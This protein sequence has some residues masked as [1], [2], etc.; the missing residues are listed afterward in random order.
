[1]LNPVHQH[2]LTQESGIAA[3]IIEERAYRTSSGY[4]ELKSLGILV[5][6][7]THTQGLLLPLWT[8]TGKPAQT[9]RAR[10]DRM[11]PLMHYR[12]DTPQVDQE[13]EEAKYLYPGGQP[14]R[15]D[16]HPRSVPL[17]QD[18]QVPLWVT[19]GVKKSDALVSHG[20]C[21]LT[22]LG[23]WNWRGRNAQGGKVALPEWQDIA[24]NGR[25]VRLVF[26]SDIMEKAPVE[27]A[28]LALA[29][30][31]TSKGAHVH[32]AYLPGADGSKVGVDDYLLTHTPADLEHLLEVP[33]RARPKTAASL[34]TLKLNKAQEPRPV[35]FNVL[36][37]L[38]QDPHW[39]GVF[40]YDAF[41]CKETLLARP[42]YL[43]DDGPWPVRQITD[44]DDTETSNWLQREYDLCAST[45][46]IHEAIQAL[47]HRHPYHPVRDYLRR[48][49]WDGTPRLETWLTTYCHAEDTPYH[50]AVG[51]K[52]LVSWVARVEEPGCKADCVTILQGDQGL[53][54]STTWEVLAGKPWFSDT[55]PDIERKDAMENLHGKWIVEL[56][57]LAVMQRSEREAIKRFVSANQDHYRP[58]Y[59]RRAVTFPRQTIFVGT[60][61]KEQI[62]QDETGNRRFWPVRVPKPCD[63]AALQRDRDQLFAE[64]FARYQAGA[65]WYL[66]PGEDTLAV[67]EQ[68]ERFEVDPWEE[69]VLLYVKSLEQVS[70]RQVMEQG[71]EWDNPLLWTQANSKRIGA[72]LRRH[73]WRHQTCRAADGTPFKGFKREIQ[74]TSVTDPPAVTDDTPP[75]GYNVTPYKNNTVTDVTDVTD[76]PIQ[77]ESENVTMTQ[78]SQ[79]VVT[80]PLWE[81]AVTTGYTGYTGYTG[82]A[83][84]TPLP[85][86]DG[87]PLADAP[88][89]CVHCR[90]T[91]FWTNTAGQP[92]C[93]RCHPQP[94]ERNCP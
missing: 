26:D 52:T 29:G 84:T 40:G 93:T 44:E 21:A 17:L 34:S 59:G 86:T 32:A 42:P 55:M 31:L 92:V 85:A 88:P 58:S 2:Q 7:D 43:A 47:A 3:Y 9:Y 82:S 10:E 91:T 76:G 22:L 77:G 33:R 8:I 73:D 56:G 45:S 28:L 80:S 30:Y 63:L 5:R 35:L 27:Q 79:N 65:Q 23:V 54:K 53:G 13:G 39:A 38:T 49:S 71:F 68:D 11:V 41:A 18:P 69:P 48:L 90:G 36:E 64:A 15:L 81:N 46:L 25:D 14:M 6:R 1:M 57:E 60:T 19:E 50:R 67:V 20:L 75:I 74:Q 87:S 37:I 83:V 78:K 12:P 61:N 62:F 16:C 94:K 89:P 4:S 51:A 66:A 70:T 72:I 24:L